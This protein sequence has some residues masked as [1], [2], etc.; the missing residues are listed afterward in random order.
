[1]PTTGNRLLR[2]A[3]ERIGLEEV[4]LRLQLPPASLDAFRRGERLVNDAILLRII[5]LL[6]GLP[7]NPS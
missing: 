7:K 5:D 1:M 3:I 2:E 6:E 4:A